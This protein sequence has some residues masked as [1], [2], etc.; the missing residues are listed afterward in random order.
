MKT[1]ADNQIIVTISLKHGQ[2]VDMVS[3][4]V[5][6]KNTNNNTVTS[7]HGRRAMQ[8]VKF[9]AIW[10][11]SPLQTS[12]GQT[13][14]L[15]PQ[16]LVAS[17]MRTTHLDTS[18]QVYDSSRTI[19]LSGQNGTRK[20]PIVFSTV[21]EQRARTVALPTTQQI[22][23]ICSMTTGTMVSKLGRTMQRPTTWEEIGCWF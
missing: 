18:R 2:L 8:K 4:N 6:R 11:T 21:R 3:R 7:Q 9:W 20:Y 22:S 15:R 14:R 17:H 19:S 5:L 10:T 16:R 1:L 23:A 13:H 12:P